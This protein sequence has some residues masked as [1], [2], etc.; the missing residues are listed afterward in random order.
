MGPPGGDV[1]LGFTT[2][3]SCMHHK[4]SC[5]QIA[6]CMR[7]NV[8]TAAP[9]GP[10]TASPPS[11]PPTLPPSL[12]P[13]PQIGKLIQHPGWHR[14]LHQPRDCAKGA[15][16]LAGRVRRRPIAQRPVV[17]RPDV[18]QAWSF[19]LPDSCPRSTWLQ[20]LVNR[21]TAR[22][23][24]SQL[25]DFRRPVSHAF[26]QQAYCFLLH[27]QGFVRSQTRRVRFPERGSQSFQQV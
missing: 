15:V 22:R 21:V 6:H 9:T 16:E 13:L 20:L 27:A 19:R 14:V 11:L 26:L 12:S 24:R 1:L 23:F 17:L 8:A 4:V 7:F 2:R 3:P 5:S 25:V 10:S 18:E